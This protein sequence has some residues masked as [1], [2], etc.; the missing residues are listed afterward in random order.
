VGQY[1]LERRYGRG[2]SR[3]QALTPMQRARLLILSSRHE[4]RS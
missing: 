4:G 3:E 2:S 1:Y